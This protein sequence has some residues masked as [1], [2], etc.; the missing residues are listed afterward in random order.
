GDVFWGHGSGVGHE[1]KIGVVH[2][3][4]R[5]DREA[6]DPGELNDAGNLD[7]AVDAL[8]SA[9]A[10]ALPGL[11]PQPAT[12][13]PC[14]VTDSPDGQFLIGRLTDSPRVVVAGGDS[15]HGFKHAAGTGELLAQIVSGE[16]PYCATDFLAPQRFLHSRP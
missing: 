15:G 5:P 1:A 2:A 14:W 3:G 9:V 10:R 16:H 6:V 8:A 7:R 13:V 4:T 11:D 12:V